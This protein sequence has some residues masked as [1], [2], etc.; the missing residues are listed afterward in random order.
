MPCG[1][2][3]FIN[4][5]LGQAR[6]K[7]FHDDKMYNNLSKHQALSNYI[8]AING[9]TGLA[10]SIG[11]KIPLGEFSNFLHQTLL[12]GT[13][14]ASGLRIYFATT[15]QTYLP[16]DPKDTLT[17]IFSP[18]LGSGNDRG[19]YHIYQIFN[20]KI[21]PV[22]PDPAS[23]MVNDFQRGKWALLNSL[24]TVAGNSS[25]METKSIYYKI[26]Y[27][28]NWECNALNPVPGSPAITHIQFTIG[29]YLI[30][31]GLIIHGKDVKHQLSLQ[32]DFFSGND[33]VVL[34]FVKKLE[35]TGDT[36]V[37]CP[38]PPP[39]ATKCPGSLPQ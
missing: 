23:N 20:K 38:P 1:T 9:T 2:T 5:Q 12:G 21:I 17:L 16:N 28:I 29:A 13:N 8:N 39:P 15:L 30:K 4:D 24:E 7:H 22:L 3:G 26:E 37:P 18:T 33:L 31:E 34:E 25:F 19:D 27:L 11:V 36:G 10:E 14:P 32:I 6:Q 35:L